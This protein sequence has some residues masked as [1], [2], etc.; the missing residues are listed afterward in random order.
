M[1]A[2]CRDVPS[3]WSIKIKYERLIVMKKTLIYLSHPYGNKKENFDEISKIME[4]LYN[5]DSFFNEFCIISPVHNY[6]ALYE[7]ME[8]DKGLQIC[9]DLMEYVDITLIVG[10]W[11]SSKGCTK[12]RKYCIE[13]NVPY[14]IVE[15]VKEILENSPE[16]TIEALKNKLK[17]QTK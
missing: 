9:I 14:I 8:Y 6:G 12:E 7:V 15:D 1:T 13:N 10:D 2:W 4:H 17:E 16:K 5:S 3:C 11:Q